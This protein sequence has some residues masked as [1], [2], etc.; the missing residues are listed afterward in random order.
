MFPYGK[1]IIIIFFA[2]AVLHYYRM[3]DT[4]GMVHSEGIKFGDLATNTD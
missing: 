2:I 3:Y 1:I 4:L